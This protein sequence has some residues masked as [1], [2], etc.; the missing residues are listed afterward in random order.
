MTHYECVLFCSMASNNET[1]Y[2]EKLSES[3]SGRHVQREVT[4][5]SW[6]WTPLQNSENLGI[7]SEYGYFG[8][9]Y[10]RLDGTG[11][12]EIVIAHRGTCFD[13]RENVLA[14][15]AI[16]EGAEPAILREAAFQY[17]TQLLGQDFYNPD[18]NVATLSIGGYSVSKITHT[19][20]SL[21]GFIAGACVGLSKSMMLE[22]VTFDAPG[23]GALN[24]AMEESRVA[25]RIVNYVTTPNLVNTCNR[26]VGEVREIVMPSQLSDQEVNF[27]VNLSDLGFGVPKQLSDKYSSREFTD[28]MKDNRLQREKQKSTN[29]ALNELNITL[30]SHNLEKMIHG[31]KERFFYKLVYKWP[32]ASNEIIYG[33]EPKTPDSFTSFGFNDVGSAI[34]S[35]IAIAFQ[36]AKQ[37]GASIL[38]GLTKKMEGGREV[39]FTGIEHRRKNTVYYSQEEYL[40][41]VVQQIPEMPMQPNQTLE[42]D[43][44]TPLRWLQS[45]RSGEPAEETRVEKTD[46]VLMQRKRRTARK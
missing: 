29:A 30:R 13:E 26:Y 11:T 7:G 31:I 23:I 21:G 3:S 24:L 12:A 35:T 17:V 19:G 46:V 28:W 43:N 5:Q 9:A 39:G 34:L 1:R 41:S 2:L 38:W 37:V 15:L 45:R 6:G 22:A 42:G 8:C 10:F 16:A 36:G 44:L 40:R 25:S 14:D 20:F 4:L 32:E 27:K 33:E 18:Q